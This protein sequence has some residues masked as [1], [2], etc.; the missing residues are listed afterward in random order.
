MGATSQYAVPAASKNEQPPYKRALLSEWGS[1][2]L[3]ALFAGALMIY[4]VLRTFSKLE[5]SYNEGWNVYNAATAD[6]H[7]PLYG[8]KYGWTTVNYPVLSFYVVAWLHRIGP[9][10][11]I[12]GRTL[13]L[14]SL[15]VSC[16]LVGLIVWRFTRDYRSAL[17][18]SLFCLAI[19]CVAANVYGLVVHGF[20]RCHH[21]SNKS[22]RD[23]TAMDQRT[24]RRTVRHDADFSGRDRTGQKI[25]DDQVDP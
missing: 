11:L 23:V 13:S 10:Y 8:Q 22:A 6:H 14:A 20:L 4:P 25:V 3:F 21:E 19:F 2:V 1:V 7:L 24:P 15:C 12:A 18:S 16:L 9:S 17:F 5:V